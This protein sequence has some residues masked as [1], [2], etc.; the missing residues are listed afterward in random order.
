MNNYRLLALDMDGTLLTDD[1]RISKKTAEAIRDAR[2]AGIT[3][4]LS[5]GRAFENAV[6]YAEE[7][8]LDSPM[9]TVNGSEV[10][11]K[12]YQIYIRHLMDREAVKRLVA[13]SESHDTWFWAYSTKRQYN[14]E[15]WNADIDSEDWLKFGYFNEDK[16]VLGSL[17]KELRL[18]GGLE[19]SNSSPDNIEINPSGIHKASGLRTVCDLIGCTM[20]QTV[21]IGD[22]LN[23]LAAIQ[24][25]GLGIAMGNAQD[26]VKRAA[27]AVVR[28]NNE[29]GIAQAIWEYVLK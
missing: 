2:E 7:L 29:D 5:T 27:D 21:S 10:W 25:S 28:T 3:V 1:H 9:V 20:S 11:K 12:P 22:S 16:D 14:R 4:I 23:D 18:I 26:D 6:P 24:A 15:N 8:G 17:W 13:L 19:L